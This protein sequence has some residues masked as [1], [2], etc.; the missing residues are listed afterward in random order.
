MKRIVMISSVV[1]L[2]AIGLLAFTTNL[3]AAG[4]EEVKKDC[5]PT[6]ECPASKWHQD[7]AA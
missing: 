6:K 5:K 7:K 1:A 3:D 4:K 2:V